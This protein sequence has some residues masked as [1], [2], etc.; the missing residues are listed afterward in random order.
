MDLA[1]LHAATGLLLA[2]L[3]VVVVDV[4]IDGFDVINDV[5]GAVLLLLGA[6]R[7]VDVVPAGR[8]TGLSLAAPLVPAV[9]LGE[10]GGIGPLALLVD[11]AVM[12][13]W[14]VVARAMTLLEWPPATEHLAARWHTHLRLTGT[15]EGV[16]LAVSAVRWVLAGRVDATVG[17][18]GPIVLLA[19]VATLGLLVHRVLVLMETRRWA[20]AASS[21]REVVGQREG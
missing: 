7:L 21:R 19:A 4:R 1:R 20:R 8:R 12:A 13:F 18:V 11:L 17:G 14:L 6:A 5:V 10:I 3:A 9:L 16:A 2:G 15:I